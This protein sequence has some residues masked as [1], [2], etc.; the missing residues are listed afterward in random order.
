MRAAAADESR[1]RRAAAAAAAAP[2]TERR[3]EMGRRHSP[4]RAT[5]LNA[6]KMRL[7]QD[8]Y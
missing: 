2:A 7:L 4:Y 3:R 6:L 1:R 8:E 5:A